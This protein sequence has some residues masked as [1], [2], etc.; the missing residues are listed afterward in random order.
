MWTGDPV[1]WLN[2]LDMHY[3]KNE[4]YSNMGLRIHVGISD[5]R[6]DIQSISELIKELLN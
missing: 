3:L 5:V 4:L 6:K 1:K 2:N